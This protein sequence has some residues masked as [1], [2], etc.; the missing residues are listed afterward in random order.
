MAEKPAQQ[1]ALHGGDDYELLFTVSPRKAASLP[2]KF[3]KLP[4][5]QIGEI[6]KERGV[7]VA[8]RDG[9]AKPLRASGWDPFRK[10][11]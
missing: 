10:E 5:T 3:R 6:T 8:R 1:L 4:L 9:I 7:R 2:A 11:K